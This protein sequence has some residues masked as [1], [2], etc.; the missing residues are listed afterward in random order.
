MLVIIGLTVV[1][2]SRI[3]SNKVVEFDTVQLDCL[4]QNIYFEAGNQSLRGMAAV[5]DVTLNRVQNS[6]YPNDICSVV[7]QGL[8]HSD[9]TMKRNMCQFSWYCDGKSDKVLT[10][11]N[12]WKKSQDIAKTMLLEYNL[13]DKGSYFGITSGSTHY[14]ATYVAPDWIH[15]RGMIRIEQIGSHIF[16]KFK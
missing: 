12:A 6:R 3:L 9:G 4:S 2:E 16:Y 10:Y 1:A 5:A 8:K 15:D 14:H 13:A 11:T 7:K